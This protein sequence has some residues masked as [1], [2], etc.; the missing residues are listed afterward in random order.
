MRGK[1]GLAECIAEA[2]GDLLEEK[3]I[4]GDFLHFADE[5]KRFPGEGL[6]GAEGIDGDDLWGAATGEESNQ[7]EEGGGK[8]GCGAGGVFHRH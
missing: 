4:L 7:D 8:G 6:V 5:T 3:V 1:A 2:G